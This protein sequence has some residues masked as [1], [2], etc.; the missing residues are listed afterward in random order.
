[1]HKLTIKEIRERLHLRKAHLNIMRKDNVE[2]FKDHG[3]REDLNHFGI[4]S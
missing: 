1:M 2:S 3:Y 4:F